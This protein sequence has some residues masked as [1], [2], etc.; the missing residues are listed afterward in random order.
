M[1]RILL[2]PYLYWLPRSLP[3][4]RLGETIYDPG[5]KICKM[6]FFQRGLARGWSGKLA[7]FKKRRWE[8]A[9]FW[10][11]FENEHGYPSLFSEMDRSPD[12]LRYPLEILDADVCKKLFEMEK[13]RGLGI[14]SGYPDS[15]DGIPELR[16]QFQGQSFP[17]AKKIVRQIVTLPLHPL[18]SEKDRLRIINSMIKM[19]RGNT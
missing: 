14:A 2:N 3:F 18:V 6:S 7:A 15:I 8:N 10:R 5:F 11:K 9:A 19:A 17:H 13:E 4:L 12:L 1:L 16:E